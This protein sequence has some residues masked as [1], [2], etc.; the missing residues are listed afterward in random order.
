MVM[1][2]GLMKL[3]A[4]VLLHRV[5]TVDAWKHGPYYIIILGS[6]QVSLTWYLLLVIL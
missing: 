2:R 1:N 6:K 3:L 4:H 5:V